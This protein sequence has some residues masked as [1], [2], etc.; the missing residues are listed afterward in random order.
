MDGKP[1]ADAD[2][3]SIGVVAANLQDIR[4]FSDTYL[5]AAASDPT[6]RTDGSDLQDGDIFFD[7]GLARWKVYASGSGTWIVS[8]TTST[9]YLT[10]D[11]SVA[12]TG[13]LQ[14]PDVVINGSGVWHPGN[15][16]AGSGLDADRI[17]GVEGAALALQSDID[18]VTE[19]MALIEADLALN[20]LRDLVDRG[21]S[22]YSMVSGVADPLKDLSGLSYLDRPIPQDEGAVISGGDGSEY[23]ALNTHGAL[24]AFD[25]ERYNFGYQ[26]SGGPTFGWVGKDWG[27][28]SA[29]RVSRVK[30]WSH[31]TR[32]FMELAG[33]CSLKVQG[34]TTGA[35][36]GEEVTLWSDATFA[37]SG[38]ASVDV[39]IPDLTT[40]Y[41]YHRFMVEETDA[42]ADI[43][44]VEVAFYEANGSLPG[45]VD[46]DHDAVLHTIAPATT[47][48][49]DVYNSFDPTMS[50]TAAG[51]I[52]RM[53]PAITQSTYNGLPV[54]VGTT[55]GPSPWLAHKPFTSV[56]NDMLR[57]SD[58][59][60]FRAKINMSSAMGGYSYYG[61]R[62]VL[63]W[64]NDPSAPTNR[65]YIAIHNDDGNLVV[66]T[67]GG[68][69][70][71]LGAIPA[72]NAWYDV[73]LD[74]RKPAGFLVGTCDVDITINGIFAGSVS[75]PLVDT[76]LIETGTWVGTDSGL[77]WTHQHDGS[78]TNTCRLAALEVSA[79]DQ[80]G[81]F[82][83]ISAPQTAAA[84]PTAAR[85][86]VVLEPIDSINPLSDLSAEI[87]R[88]DGVTWTMGSLDL[89][90]AN[91]ATST[92]YSLEEVDLSAQPTGDQIRLRLTTPTSKRFRVHAWTLQWR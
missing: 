60:I 87:S 18:G 32:G 6:T 89:T 81:A 50:H 4:N 33:L 75:I 34:S 16:G 63:L 78:L 13:A 27:A 9:E 49:L 17:D 90:S 56:Q 54:W 91:D 44:I 65:Q 21:W 28:G 58:R 70:T 5:G 39:S 43:H 24:H 35:W 14:A 48:A 23:T 15:Q 45:S 36:A 8:Y 42:G 72:D 77:S 76:Q 57:D 37:N 11:G 30:A 41:R 29:R 46:F 2:V 68:G 51:W 62:F 25:G 61:N 20:T 22:I 69:A 1:R 31:E 71:L 47:P 84:D 7:T 83:M 53:S 92:V 55:N 64:V 26:R 10:R 82:S 40:A 59:V 12:M 85:A 86:I 67:T 3:N 79:G 73:E 80:V 88:D 66:Q 52:D 38:A 74:I 19:R